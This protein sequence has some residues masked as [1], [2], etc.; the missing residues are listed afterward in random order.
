MKTNRLIVCLTL[1]SLST[2]AAAEN[3]A[4]FRGP[5]GAGISHTKGI[6]VTWTGS[7]YK[8]KVPVPGL[9][10]GSPC[11]WGDHIFLCSA[12]EKGAVRVVMDIDSKN[13]RIRWIKRFESE[14][15]KKHNLNSYA[16]CTPAS[17]GE[18]VYA[19]FTTENDSFMV[20]FD[21]KGKQL[22]K[23]PLGPFFNR[24]GHGSGTSP[25]VYKDKVILSVQQDGKSFVV[26]LNSK[27]GKEKWRRTCTNR[28]T[29]HA[30]PFILEQKEKQPKLFFTNTGDGIC[31][32]NANTGK[33][34][35]R[36]NV[37][38]ARA[39]GSPI[40]VNGEFVTATCGG[41]GRGRILP[42]IPVNGSGELKEED[43]GWVL[44]KQLPYVCTPIAHKDLVFLWG[45]NGVA[46]CIEA[47]SGKNVWTQRIGGVYS[48]SPIWIDGKIYA[49]KRS[50]ECVV[51]SA[52]REKKVLG[53]SS[54]GEPSHS[55]PAVANGQLLIRGFKHLF[56]LEAKK[57]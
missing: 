39:V 52:G 20:A 57:K 31:C 13:G 11:V 3:W 34:I 35:F 5:Q 32:L 49:V 30:T 46:R 48:G 21:F 36:A 17:D 37:F 18:R 33:D 42:A 22:W 7:D 41:G 6:P 53:Q 15:H 27:T 14:T 56:C 16:S 4:R 2:V 40:L 26:A 9:G 38:K 47:K 25:I 19:Y 50:G 45:D 55:T 51:I 24:H 28:L 54:L 23:T 12:L 29:G 1:L 44:K 10:H 8:W 43:A